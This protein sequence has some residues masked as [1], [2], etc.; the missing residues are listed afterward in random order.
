MKSVT[1]VIFNEPHQNGGKLSRPMDG[2]LH[3]FS[4][5]I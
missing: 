2:E 3:I 4:G 5:I 1:T